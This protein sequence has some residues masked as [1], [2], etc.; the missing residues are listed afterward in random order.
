MSAIT[1]G[2]RAVSV[3]TASTALRT[4]RARIS[5]WRVAASMSSTPLRRSASSTLSATVEVASKKLSM[6]SVYRVKIS[7]AN[8]SLLMS[9][10][11]S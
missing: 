8:S 2:S 3:T 1:P 4:M 9:I 6:R 5:P 10:G 7:S 11:P